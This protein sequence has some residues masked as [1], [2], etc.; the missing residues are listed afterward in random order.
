MAQIQILAIP[1]MVFSTQEPRDQIDDIELGFSWKIED[2]FA[3]A[4][5]FGPPEDDVLWTT[6]FELF[7]N[8]S[9]DPKRAWHGEG[10][11]SVQV[12]RLSAYIALKGTRE[13]EDSVLVKLPAGHLVLWLARVFEV[14]AENRSKIV[15]AVSD[16][17]DA[18]LAGA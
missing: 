8:A 15:K 17:L 7:Y 5:Q 1:A 18:M 10:D 11:V 13:G 2:P 9:I 3:L 4:I 6:S 12:H 16:E 14:R